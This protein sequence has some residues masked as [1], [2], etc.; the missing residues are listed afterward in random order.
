MNVELQRKY[1]TYPP[2]I[3]SKLLALR[4]LIIEVIETNDLGDFEETLKW[5]EPSFLVKAGSTVRFDW[6]ERDKEHYCIYFNCNTKLVDTFRE[7]YSDVLVF[8]GNRAIVLKVNDSLPVDAIK[9]CV[10]LSLR[11]WSIKDQPLLGT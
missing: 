10:E 4:D 9:H 2:H 1:D 5:D 3:K 6:K 7:L 11:Y 8:E